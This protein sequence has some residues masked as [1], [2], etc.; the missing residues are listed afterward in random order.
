MDEEGREP[1]HIRWLA[2][3]R[4]RVSM[5]RR[6]AADVVS[7]IT[8]SVAVILST[9]FGLLELSWLHVGEGAA[10]PQSL[11]FD[12]ARDYEEA[13]I[14]STPTFTCAVDV[15]S[16]VRS[17]PCTWSARQAWLFGASN[18]LRRAM[19]APPCWWH[20]SADELSAIR[21][22]HISYAMLAVK[23]RDQV[24]GRRLP[25]ELGEL[26]GAGRARLLE[27]GST[28]LCALRPR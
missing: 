6:L 18:P 22:I 19:G 12:A 4:E 17:K 16:V 24:D 3:L 28:T 21:G 20:A 14:T 7:V 27:G 5:S 13:V 23:A 2:E 15:G 1:L 10:H 8:V 25:R 26:V 9:T 11:E